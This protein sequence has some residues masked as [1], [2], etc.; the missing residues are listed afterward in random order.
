M[1]IHLE[2]K[3]RELKNMKNDKEMADTTK[4][5]RQINKLNV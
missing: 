3:K 2:K 5:S 4:G 1:R